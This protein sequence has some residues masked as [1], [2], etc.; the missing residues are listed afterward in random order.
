MQVI[1]PAFLPRIPHELG[2]GEEDEE[3]WLRGKEEE[4]QERRE[5]MCKLELFPKPVGVKDAAEQSDTVEL[6]YLSSLSLS[7]SLFLFLF[8]FLFLS[9][10]LSLSLFLFLFL[11]PQTCGG[12]RCCRTE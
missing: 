9:L 3:A 6:G 12:E 2:S 1:Y 11:F 8:V 10:S 4:Q 5:E 7:L